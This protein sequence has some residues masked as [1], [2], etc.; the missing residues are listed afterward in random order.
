MADR[1]FAPGPITAG[2]ATLTG[3]E[4]R[5]LARVRRLGPGDA[6][7]LLDG[8]GGAWLAVVDRVERDRVELAVGE[9]LPERPDGPHLTLA[10][11]VP[12]GERFDWL[13]EKATELGV[14]RL[15]PILASRSTVD[16]RSSKLDRL[17]RLVVEACKQSGRRRLMEI[18][19]TTPWPDACRSESPGARF[20][21]HPG[22]MPA[23]SAIAGAPAGPLALAIGPEGG[24][25]PDEVA[26][27]VAAGWR[28]IDLGPNLLRIE[29]AA[30]AGAA[31]VLAIARSKGEPS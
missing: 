25:D 20:L 22:G 18:G 29:T 15:V 24:F 30:L 12:K 9:P 21:A 10:T 27:A 23:A 6:V 2:R 17:R 1:V 7:E 13:V 19:P 3:D 26:G 16:P 8:R 14:A 11:A 31:S 28:L 4:A 5:H